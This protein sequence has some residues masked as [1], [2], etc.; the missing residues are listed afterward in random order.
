M[1]TDPVLQA[2]AAQP[3]TAIRKALAAKALTTA[4]IIEATGYETTVVLE[5]LH[6]LKAD[7]NTYGSPATGYTKRW[8][9]S[10]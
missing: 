2:L 4:E 7:V 9:L 3:L 10:A 8:T 6:I 1:A 5:A